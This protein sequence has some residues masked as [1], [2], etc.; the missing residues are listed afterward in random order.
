MMVDS[1]TVTWITDCLTPGPQFVRV[2]AALSDVVVSDVGAPHE[3]VL[4]PFLFIP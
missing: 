1:P 2:G 3:T 4:S